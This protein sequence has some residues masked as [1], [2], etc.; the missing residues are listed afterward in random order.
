MFSELTD[1]L[2]IDACGDRQVCACCFCYHRLLRLLRIVRA[3]HQLEALFLM[4]TALRGCCCTHDEL[5][6]F[7]LH[8]C[9]LDSLLAP[10]DMFMFTHFDGIAEG[11]KCEGLLLY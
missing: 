9:N 3:L 4:T 11:K 1:S 8:V 5:R 10:M 7:I 6:M 2:E